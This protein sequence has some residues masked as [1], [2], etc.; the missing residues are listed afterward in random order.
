MNINRSN[1][2]IYFLD[3]LD[4]NLPE[5]QV[6]DFLDFLK[7]NPDL[8]EELKLVSSIKLS[9]DEP[10]FQNK[11]ALLK[12]E[13]TGSSIFDYQSIAY[14]EDDLAEDDKTSF[15]HQIT[16]DNAKGEQ[17]D[18]FLKTKLQPDYD[19]IFSNKE[20][21]HKKRVAA[22][23]LLWGSRAAAVVVLLLGIWAIWDFSFNPETA[24]QYA[25]QESVVSTK[26]LDNENES[27][28]E[29]VVKNESPDTVEEKPDILMAKPIRQVQVKIKKQDV[30]VEHELI[31]EKK[32]LV[33]AITPIAAEVET[34]STLA[35]LSLAKM[36]AYLIQDSTEYL[37]VDEYLAEKFLNKSKGEP[38]TASGLLSAGLNA[39]SNVSHERLNYETSPNGKISGISLNT[40]L[41]AFSLPF[42][43]DN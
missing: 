30:I 28:R 23:F 16:N 39:V 1:Y 22:V 2:E 4:G 13:M 40:R 11:E 20:K 14:L 31:A 25:E 9:V 26:K 7:N 24:E 5:S 34:S 41:L 19:I 33:L 35:P 38:I 10:V 32:E 21:L 36:D 42:K 29:L 8:N 43:K 17:F 18:L 3:Y 37:T 12:N 15:L 27:F 6:D